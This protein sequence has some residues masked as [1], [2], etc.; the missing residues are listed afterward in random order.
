VVSLDIQNLTLPTDMNNGVLVINR[1]PISQTNLLDNDISYNLSVSTYDISNI[2][3]RDRNLS[4]SNNQVINSN[5]SLLGNICI[6][7]S[8]SYSSNS[9]LDISGNFLQNNG[10]ISQ[11]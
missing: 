10:W 8:A 7:H 6:N 1:N 5:I 4:T 11:F 9:A 3:L 2:V